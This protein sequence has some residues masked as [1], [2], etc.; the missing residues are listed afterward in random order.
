MIPTSCDLLNN[1]IY[2]YSCYRPAADV[3]VCVIQYQH[4]TSRSFIQSSANF[5]IEYHGTYLMSNINL[6]IIRRRHEK[7]DDSSQSRRQTCVSYNAPSRRGN[8]QVSNKT[9]RGKFVISK[10]Y[11]KK[12]QLLTHPKK[13]CSFQGWSWPQFSRMAVAT[14]LHPANPNMHRKMSIS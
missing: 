11:N 2:Q 9:C 1:N 4:V 13:G 14:I 5:V 8:I 10:K 3:F 12:K 7:Y 6:T